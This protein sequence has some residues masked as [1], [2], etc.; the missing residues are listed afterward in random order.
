MNRR[1]LQKLVGLM[2]SSGALDTATGKVDVDKL[3]GHW[4]IEDGGRR[5]VKITREAGADD[6]QGGKQRGDNGGADAGRR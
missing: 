4:S 6:N 2:V 1:E 3:Q 5:G